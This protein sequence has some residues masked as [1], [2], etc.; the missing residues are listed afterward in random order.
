MEKNENMLGCPDPFSLAEFVEGTK[1]DWTKQKDEFET[2]AECLGITR[3][4]FMDNSTAILRPFADTQKKDKPVVLSKDEAKAR[5]ETLMKK[6]ARPQ[7]T[8]RMLKKGNGLTFQ[9]KRQN[10]INVLLNKPEA[11]KV[12]N[13]KVKSGEITGKTDD[14]YLPTSMAWRDKGYYF[15]ETVHW[16]DINQNSIADCYFLSALCSVAYVNPFLIKNVTGLRFK[17][18]E[19]IQEETP[20]HAIEFYVPKGDYESSTTWSNA[21]GTT[22]T[23]V[24]S[25]EVLVHDSSNFNYGVSG[26]KEKIDKVV[27]GDKSKMDSCW[28]AVYEKAYAKFLQACTSDYPNMDGLIHYGSA[29]GS[30]KEILHTEDAIIEYLSSLTTTQI[31]NLASNANK[32]PSCAV[33]YGPKV[34]SSRDYLDMGFYTYHAYSLFGCVTLDNKKYVIIRNPHGVNPVALKNNSHVYHKDWVIRHL[35]NSNNAYHGTKDI[36]NY[37]EGTDD[38]KTSHG[39]FLLELDEFKRIFTTIEHYNGPALEFGSTSL[40]PSI[41]VIPD[42]APRPIKEPKPI[43]VPKPIKE[44]IVIKEPIKKTKSKK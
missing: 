29:V 34:G 5:L 35:A 21:K 24:V 6:I 11:A 44:P 30:I 20:W 27:S 31:W 7:S 32:N 16:Y 13:Q 42:P 17:Y 23:I 36:C 40:V 12:V 28:P 18:S 14:V 25:E 3:E 39:I 22:Q 10:A 1:I 33:I 41:A 9:K 4:G 19:G 43:K 37:L 38:P 8:T 15:N 2:V 26:P